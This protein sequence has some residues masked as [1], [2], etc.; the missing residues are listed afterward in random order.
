M[1]HIYCWYN[2]FV[3]YLATSSKTRLCISYDPVIPLLSTPP[4]ISHTRRHLQDVY[5][6]SSWRSNI[7]NELY[8]TVIKKKL[9]MFL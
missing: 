6:N 2:Y 8:T 1:V 5:Y 4:E 9:Q 7:S 3:E